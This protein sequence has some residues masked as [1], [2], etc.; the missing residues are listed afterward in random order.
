MKKFYKLVSVEKTPQGFA[1]HLD[2]R[3]VK[4]KSGQIVLSSNLEMANAV[5][6]EWVDQVEDILPD[7]MPLTQ[8]LNTKIDR[9]ALEREVMSAEILKY[10]DTDLLCYRTGD[11]QPEIATAQVKLL[12][13]WLRWFEEKFSEELFT[14]TGLAALKQPKIA[15]EKIAQYVHLIDDDYFTILQLVTSI[16][17]SIILGI[18]FIEGAATAAQVFDAARVEEAY[19]DE[20]YN[21]QK[22]GADPMQEK[23]DEIARFDLEAAEHYLKLLKG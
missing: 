21:A 6:K 14:T 5:M 12:D 20:L 2:G 13:P 16:S 9:V 10:F 8:I 19:K 11:D 1:V 17:G 22:Y 23:K 7:T 3:P 4:T 15:H 18:A